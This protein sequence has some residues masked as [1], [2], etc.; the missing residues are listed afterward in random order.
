M[1]SGEKDEDGGLAFISYFCVLVLG[2]VLI[3]SIFNEELSSDSVS[4]WSNLIWSIFVLI[5]SSWVFFYPR[6]FLHLNIRQAM[7]MYNK[8]HIQFYNAIA[9]GMR[10]YYLVEFARAMGL[11]FLLI[12]LVKLYQFV[13]YAYFT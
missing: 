6:K 8:T 10:R 1:I 5:L 2:Y 11:L 9:E 3:P 12:A 7:W 4:F 13:L